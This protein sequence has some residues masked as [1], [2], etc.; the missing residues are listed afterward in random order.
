MIIV[1]FFRF[2]LIGVINTC[3]NYLV[4]YF[5]LFKLNL[6]ILVSGIIGFASTVGPAYF[7]NRAWSFRSKI[8]SVS[9]FA[10]YIYLN[11][12]TLGVHTSIQ[13]F[14]VFKMDIPDLWSQAICITVTTFLN[15]FLVR[16]YVFITNQNKNQ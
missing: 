6:P 10:K 13:W 9:G 4:F 2:C 14:I 12:L 16:R 7:A 5:C 15:F 11:F 8:P 3:L 1:Q